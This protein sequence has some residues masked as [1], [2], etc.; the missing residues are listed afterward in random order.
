MTGDRAEML[1]RLDVFVGEW[2]L[3]A[4]FPGDQPSTPAPGGDGPMARS[5]FEWALDGQVLV[6][7][8]EIPAPTAPDGL[9]IVRADP[10]TGSYTQ[11]YFDSRGVARLYSMS[12]DGG[13]WTLTRESPDFTPLEFRQR[14]TGTF[15]EDTDTITGGWEVRFDGGEWEHDFALTYRR[16]G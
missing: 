9:M 4:R 13:V 8:T 6:Q 2:V 12:F 10:G 1:E 7:R 16:A 15:S 5:R 14:F 11:H 3:E